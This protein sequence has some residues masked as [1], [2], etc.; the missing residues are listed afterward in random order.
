MYRV[1]NNRGK[2]EGEEATQIESK[3]RGS[4]KN[5]FLSPLKFGPGKRNQ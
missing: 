3:T 5:L 2:R 1:K 4:I